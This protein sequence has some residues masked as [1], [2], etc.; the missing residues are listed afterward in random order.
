MC[1]RARARARVCVCVYVCDERPT[2]SLG[3]IEVR[4][5][6]LS[7]TRQ[8]GEAGGQCSQ[9]VR[10]IHNIGYYPGIQFRLPCTPRSIFSW[11]LNHLFGHPECET[12]LS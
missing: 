7:L 10:F 6:I 4:P 1:V 11:V 3:H 8:T 9:G 2:I 5:Q 12:K